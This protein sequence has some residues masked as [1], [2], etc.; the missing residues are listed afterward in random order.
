[1]SIYDVLEV[2]FEES[3]FGEALLVLFLVALVYFFVFRRRFQS[4]FDPLVYVLAL[5]AIAQ[6]LLLLMGLHEIVSLTKVLFVLACLSLFY[7]GFL[8]I[9]TSKPRVPSG[10]TRRS[11]PLVRPLAGGT[12]ATLFLANLLILAT[13]YSLFG[14]PLF[15]E[16]RLSQF[17]DSGGFGVL[18]RLQT[19]IEF[20]SLVLA[21]LGVRQRGSVRLWAWAIVVLFVISALL[22]GSKGSLLAAVFAW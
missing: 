15:L 4:L 2:L 16:S 7:A 10:S 14:I 18:N 12:L 5:S 11:D 1:M 13:T 19:G 20:S 21:F 9:D 3:S 8:C 22:S 6:A 17:A